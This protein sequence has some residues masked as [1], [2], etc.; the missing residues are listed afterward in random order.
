MVV[1]NQIDISKP[2]EI[3]QLINQLKSLLDND[4]VI[5][6]VFFYGPAVL[7]S[8]INKA[9]KD[10]LDAW[11]SLNIPLFVCPNSAV[12][13][14]VYDAN[15]AQEY[16][17]EV[18]LD[19]KFSVSSL[20]QFFYVLLGRNKSILVDIKTHFSKTSI[21]FEEVLDFILM[22]ASLDDD[23]IVIFSGE[24]ENLFL[25]HQAYFE[26]LFEAYDL[27]NFFLC[28]QLVGSEDCI[29]AKSTDVYT[30]VF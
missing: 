3:H 29:Q 13:R 18:S 27:H 26:H 15:L 28:S 30:V 20:T 11:R 8:D 9:P 25:Q 12:K 23:L 7:Q 1:F 6:Q 4:R 22:A 5:E 17:A 14:K 24:G 2:S 16:N 21:E 19:E 10:I